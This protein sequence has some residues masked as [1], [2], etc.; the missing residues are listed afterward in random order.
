M[1]LALLFSAVL[2][3]ITGRYIHACFWLYVITFNTAEN[4]KAKNMHVYNVL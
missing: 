3:V 4:N 1:F 2:N